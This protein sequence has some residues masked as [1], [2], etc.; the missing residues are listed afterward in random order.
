MQ[1][2][3]AVVQKLMV[4]II[5]AFV[6]LAASAADAPKLTFKFST[7]QIK[8]A[9]DTRV[10]GT[11][12]AGVLVGA[13]VD[14][15]GVDHGFMMKGTKLTK[16]DDPNGSGTN[17][18]GINT[19]G[20]VVGF[21]TNSGGVSQGFL[22]HAGKFKDIAPSGSTSSEAVG[23]N[24][25]GEISGEYV[26]ASGVTHGFIWNGKKYKKLDVP[27]AASTFGW[28]INNKGWV[29]VQWTLANITHSAIYNGT[30]YMKVDVPGATGSYIHGI[31][32]AGDVVY[33][34]TDNN[35][36]FHGALRTGGKYY[37]FNDPK[38]TDGTYGDGINDN[39]LVVG[40]YHIDSGATAEGFKATY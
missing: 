28:G 3:R 30:K 20:D 11:N 9:L 22:R 27:G 8:T 24:D 1:S 29:T 14:S 10:F 25:Q 17:C 6:V 2:P 23:I 40:V 34:W 38:G 37:K 7:V 13:Y 5:F 39:H 16:I 36:V 15:G 19:A 12:N 31:N 26:D 21:Y 18:L 4:G 35:G 32:T 33:S